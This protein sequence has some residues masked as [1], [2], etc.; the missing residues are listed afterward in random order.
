MGCLQVTEDLVISVWLLLDFSQG[1][2]CWGGAEEARRV[3]CA[4]QL[5]SNSD[6]LPCLHWLRGQHG[7]PGM[8]CMAKS[9]LAVIVILYGKL[10]LS[11]SL[12]PQ[13]YATLGGAAAQ[14][15]VR[16]SASARRVARGRSLELQTER[17]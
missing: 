6:E 9:C 7:Q 11:S 17:T 4:I 13:D 15:R 1:P 2:F 3:S 10:K 14:N 16:R 5:I 8:N 12:V